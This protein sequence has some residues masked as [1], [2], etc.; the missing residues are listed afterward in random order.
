LAGSSSVVSWA[1]RVDDWERS[2]LMV[3]VIHVDAKSATLSDFGALDRGRGLYME[4][5]TAPSGAADD[6]AVSWAWQE[7]PPLAQDTVLQVRVTADLM[8]N[9]VR[10]AVE[11]V[12]CATAE[13]AA[14]AAAHR[15]LKRIEH[16]SWVRTVPDLQG[17][18]F[19]ASGGWEM[20]LTLMP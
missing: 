7:M 19:Y 9:T 4:G 14:G 1:V 2:A 16:V 8:A 17:C 13:V 12:P 15:E 3:G 18:R 5:N 11:H 10:F 6:G 20:R